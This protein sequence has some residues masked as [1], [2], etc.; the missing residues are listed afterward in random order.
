MRHTLDGALTRDALT[1]ALR[2][3]QPGP[4]V[5]HHTDRGSQY[6]AG[7]YLTLLTAQG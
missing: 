2:R 6:A 3:R 7:E 1:M 5:L 4:S